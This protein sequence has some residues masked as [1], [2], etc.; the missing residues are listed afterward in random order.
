MNR[1]RESAQ[2]LMRV[3]CVSGQLCPELAVVL[4]D[5]LNLQM[6]KLHALPGLLVLSVLFL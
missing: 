6:E 1:R 4:L 3:V 2:I 5:L